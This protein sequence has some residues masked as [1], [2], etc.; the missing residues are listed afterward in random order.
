M[1][2][3]HHGF[4]IL[5]AIENIAGHSVEQSDLAGLVLRRG[6]QKQPPEFLPTISF[7]DL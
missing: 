1:S 4:S 3:G 7:Y 2:Q 5:G 6:K